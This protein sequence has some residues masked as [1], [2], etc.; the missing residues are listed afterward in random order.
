MVQVLRLKKKNFDQFVTYCL[1][2]IMIFLLLYDLK[3]N[4]FISSGSFDNFDHFAY[5]CFHILLNKVRFLSF[6]LK[7][8]KIFLFFCSQ[9]T[10]K[11]PRYR[12]ILKPEVYPYNET[13]AILLVLTDSIFY[14]FRCSFFLILVLSSSS[15]SVFIHEDVSYRFT[16]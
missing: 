5:P 9:A 3:N 16:F 14:S 6:W 13:F 4:F 8:S 15:I 11:F 12:L 7:L 2:Q 1:L 10:S